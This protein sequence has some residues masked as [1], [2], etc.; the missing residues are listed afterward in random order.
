[1]YPIPFFNPQT[2][3]W[4]DAKPY[5]NKTYVCGFC[6]DKVS[7]NIGYWLAAHGAL[8]HHA[9]IR[10]CPN[11]GGPTFFTNENQQIPAASLGNTV[12]HVPT[13]LNALYEEARRC[14]T[15]TCYTA[16]VLLCRKML[17]N[18]AV[19]RGA[20]EGKKFEFY[21]DY[22]AKKGHVP[23]EGKPWIDHIR[24]QGNKATHKIEL[25]S[26]EEASH[27]LTFTEML[28]RTIYEFPARIKP[29]PLVTSINPIQPPAAKSPTAPTGFQ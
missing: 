21:V 10:I 19:N 12:T 14:T 17:M 20:K 23:S 18:I 2:Y 1:M 13:D 24:K 29:K 4:K 28:L 15:T 7:S 22:L 3:I 25:S 26:E 5:P 27:L 11:C 6:S 8:E 9:G 16:A